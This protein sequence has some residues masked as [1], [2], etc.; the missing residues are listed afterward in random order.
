MAGNERVT[1]VNPV[2]GECNDARLSDIRRRPIE[3]ADVQRAL[4]DAK[5]GPVEEG[6][7]GAGRGTVA[8]G[9]KGGIGTSSRKL[10]VALGGYTL[11]VLVQSNFGGVLSIAGAPIGIELG[12]HLLR[13]E[14]QQKGSVIIVVATDGPLS[15]RQLQRVGRRA[16]LGIGRTGSPMAHGSGD[17]V[18]AFATNDGPP[19]TDASLTPLF[20]AAVEATEEAVYNS[21]FKATTV[22]SSLGTVEA[23]PLDRV[24]K[25]LQRHALVPAP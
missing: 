19:P 4:R 25:L 23:L 15:H 1:S 13:D 20:Q 6:S 5:A 8:F 12:Q 9:W 21:L 14:L 2:V 7:V 11:G 16:L 22:R 24:K 18:V 10:P 17:F 3:E